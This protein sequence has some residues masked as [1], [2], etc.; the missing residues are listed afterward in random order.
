MTRQPRLTA[1]QIIRLLEKRGFKLNRQSG[2]HMIFKNDGGRRVTV[3]Y[4]AGKILHP[5]LLKSILTDA[6]IS[7]DELL[8]DIS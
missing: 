5:K 3:P 2:S 6:D 7:I 1:A 4:H 8:K